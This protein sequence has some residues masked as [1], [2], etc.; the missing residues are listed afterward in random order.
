M[1]ALNYYLSLR[2]GANMR[3]EKVVAGTSPLGITADVEVN[4]QINDGSVATGIRRKEVIQLLKVI[5]AYI[6]DGGVQGA[7]TYLPAG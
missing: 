6:N 2:R 5:E 4:I 3:P 1:A 7:G